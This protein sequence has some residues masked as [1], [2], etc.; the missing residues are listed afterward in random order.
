MTR[1]ALVTGASSGLGREF[2]KRIDAGDTGGVDEIWAVAR[3]ADRL[4]ALVRTCSTR[5]RPF[6]LDLS[7]PMSFDIIEGALAETEDADVTL[8]VNNAGFGVFGDFALEKRGEAS[9]MLSVLVKAP[10]ELMYRTLP[11]MHSGSRIINVASVAA[12]LPQPRLAVYAAAKRFILDITRALDAELGSVNIHATALCPKFMKTE[13]L[14]AAGDADVARKMSD[15][16]GFERIDDVVTAALRASRAGRSLCI[17]SW[18]MRAYY[19]ASRVV[20]Y[21]LA[22]KLERVLGAL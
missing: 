5:V 19:V 13:F 22:L 11:Y 14:D 21:P 12:F 20:P 17:P 16:I 8:L 4:D 7:D 6:C 10:V 2:V 3:R 15:A 9:D 18:D 1:I